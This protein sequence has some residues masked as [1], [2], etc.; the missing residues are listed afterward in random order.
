MIE[1]IPNMPAHSEF[2][3]RLKPKPRYSMLA[4]FC[5]VE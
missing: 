1:T 3:T 5:Y 2:L 4:H